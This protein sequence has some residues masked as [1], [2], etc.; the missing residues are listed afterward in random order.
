MLMNAA[1][2]VDA[3]KQTLN[4]LNVFPVPD[5]DTGTNMSMTLSYCAREL[6]SM[7]TDRIG[8]IAERSASLLIRGSH[9][10][11]GVITSLL[12]GGMA[13]FLKE[14][15]SVG[16][17]EFAEAMKS[18]VEK[19]YAVVNK[20]AEGTIL[21]VARKSAEAA[22]SAAG[23]GGLEAFFETVILAAKTALDLT[24]TQNPVLA[25]AGV[26]D[27]GGK[28]YVFIL[29]GMLAAVRGETLSAEESA[30]AGKTGGSVF[31]AFDTEDIKFGYCTEFIIMRA[32]TEDSAPL[33][34]FLSGI[35]DSL[36]MLDD[37]GMI[38]IHVHTNNP[39]SVLERALTYGAL[40]S[41]KIE[42]MRQQHTEKLFSAEAVAAAE[43]PPEPTKP[44]GFVAVSAGP[45]VDQI[46]RDLGADR[47]VEGGQT[48]N[49]STEA[50]LH[51]VEYT[52]AETVFVLPNNKNIILAAQQAVDLTKKTVIVL[53]TRSVPE[54]LTAM[55]NFDENASAE[56]NETVMS[57][58]FRKVRT[59]LITYAARDSEFDGIAF[60]AGDYLA[61]ANGKLSMTGSDFESV[62]AKLAD[63]LNVAESEVITVLC[64]EGADAILNGTLQRVFAQKADSLTDVSVIEG[65]QPVYYYIIGVE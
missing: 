6:E 47:I 38:K 4:E 16:Q 24:P 10:N 33:H 57:E 14:K 58:A 17:A 28:G 41:I 31:E 3:K 48:M 55:M 53:Q 39:G 54:G 22:A 8:K 42:N 18:G 45:G 61:L 21:T 12:F 26:V 5:G 49:P 15:D 20:P 36:V 11:S 23:Q 43:A 37:E 64:G 44:F 52:P 59:G 35:G 13:K 27:A 1:A 34:D 65:G 46:F 50:I 51:A 63:D 56:E 2:M 7:N 60:R 25:K 9:G 30:G 32:G 19:A 40:T 29:E 62:V